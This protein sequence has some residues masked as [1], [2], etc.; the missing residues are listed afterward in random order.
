MDT[1]CTCEF[2]GKEVTQIGKSAIPAGCLPFTTPTLTQLAILSLPL[3]LATYILWRLKQILNTINN[4]GASI[5]Q[6]T[7]ASNLQTDH[8]TDRQRTS[9]RPTTKTTTNLTS[10]SLN[11]HHTPTPRPRAH[12]LDSCTTLYLSTEHTTPNNHPTIF[13]HQLSRNT[14][15]HTISKP[16]HIHPY[17]P[18]RA[19][20]VALTFCTEHGVAAPT[21]PYGIYIIKFATTPLLTIST[22]FPLFHLHR[23][24]LQTYIRSTSSPPPQHV[25]IRP[26]FD[27]ARLSLLNRYPPGYKYTT[28]KVKFSRRSNSSSHPAFATSPLPFSSALVP[29]ISLPFKLIITSHPHNYTTAHTSTQLTSLSHPSPS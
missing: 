22:P 14:H 19:S 1:S 29:I 20:I 15:T 18:A 25:R 6:A 11:Y 21:V 7:T 27:L 2:C 5:T 26:S 13:Q 10:H 24:L 8:N 17:L 9:V 4:P 3:I 28:H 12:H 23:L 16:K